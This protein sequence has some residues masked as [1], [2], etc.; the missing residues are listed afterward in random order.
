MSICL[1]DEIEIAKDILNKVSAPLVYTNTGLKY[2][3]KKK[4]PRKYKNIW[5]KVWEITSTSQSY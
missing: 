1:D 5:L 3:L 2:I 4:M